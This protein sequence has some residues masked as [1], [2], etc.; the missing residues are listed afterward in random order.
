[1]AQDQVKDV[2][3]DAEPVITVMIDQAGTVTSKV[4]GDKPVPSTY[5]SS[6]HP[7]GAIPYA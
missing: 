6:S 2:Y 4:G 3:P 7:D 1:M 5:P